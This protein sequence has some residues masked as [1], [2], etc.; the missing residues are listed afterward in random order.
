MDS[1]VI[2]KKTLQDILNEIQNGKSELASN[3]QV[4]EELMSPRELKLV[5]AAERSSSRLSRKDSDPICQLSPLHMELAAR[6]GYLLAL[7]WLVQNNA[8]WRSQAIEWAA[9]NGH[10]NCL[11]YLYENG[12]P[13]SPSAIQYAKKNDH[14]DCVDYLLSQ[15]KK[16]E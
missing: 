8:P 12:A 1:T 10:L 5:E 16:L 4:D 6:N 2:D 3:G 7:V 14:M 13:Y 9:R 11:T 15:G